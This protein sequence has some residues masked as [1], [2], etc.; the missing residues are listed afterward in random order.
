MIRMVARTNRVG[1][2]LV[3]DIVL[4]GGP[5]NGGL[6]GRVPI[7]TENSVP[8]SARYARSFKGAGRR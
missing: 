3:L 1:V 2:D 8:E 6:A 7:P 5:G 4:A